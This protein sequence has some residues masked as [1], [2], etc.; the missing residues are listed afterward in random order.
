M[1]PLI[2]R[3]ALALAAPVRA[4]PVAVTVRDKGVATRC[5]EEDNVYAS[6]SGPRVQAFQVTARQPAY[7]GTLTENVYAPDFTDCGST[8]SHDYRFKPRPPVI[9]YEDDQVR[10]VGVTYGAYWRPERVRVTVAGRKD[11][12]FHLIQLFV[13]HGEDV[14]EALVLHAAD[15][16]WRLRPLPL[17]QFGGSVYGSSFLI[18]PIEETT[19]PFV[20]I[21]QITVDPKALTFRLRFVKGGSATLAVKQI[22]HDQLS[23]AVALTPR[24]RARP[25]LALRSM[26]VAPDNADAAQI[27]WPG[28]TAPAVGFGAVTARTFGFTRPIPS[29]HNAAAPDLI[30]ADFTD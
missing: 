3:A 22:D 27:E 12:G 23:A 21:R 5:A 24:V 28:H 9:L 1:R 20:R 13:K 8:P 15:G 10:I 19:R 14:Q 25:F 4:A 18:G 29:K 2:V 30:F 7:G 17:P 26:Y 11:R 16:Y 6:V